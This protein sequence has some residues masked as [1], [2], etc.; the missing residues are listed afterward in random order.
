M[1]DI[2]DMQE[3][4]KL[5]ILKENF[6][7]YL[8]KKVNLLI[9]EQKTEETKNLFHIAVIYNIIQAPLNTSNIIQTHFPHHLKTISSLVHTLI[10]HTAN[11]TIRYE[12]RYLSILII[13]IIDLLEIFMARNF[14]TWHLPSRVCL[15]KTDYKHVLNMSYKHTN[16]I[17]LDKTF[18]SCDS[19]L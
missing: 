18:S 6:Y 19:L 13:T 3:R 16:P 2:M 17:F 1:E 14:K 5:G 15:R 4:E 12:I 8:Y 7:I 10:L 11:R 9:E